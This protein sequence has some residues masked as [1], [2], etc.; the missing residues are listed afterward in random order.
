MTTAQLFD[1]SVMR[2]IRQAS[3][4]LGDNLYLV[5]GAARD[6]LLSGDHPTDWDFATPLSTDEVITLLGGRYPIWEAGR[7]F[8]TIGVYINGSKVDITTFR[9]ET[10]PDDTRFPVINYTDDLRL[11]T[12]RRD[13]T[14][15]SIVLDP[16]GRVLD[17]HGGMDDL[18][19][20][21][22]RAVGVPSERFREDPLRIMRMYRFA[23]KYRFR[24]DERTLSDAAQM[25]IRILNVSRERWAME[26]E[27]ILQLHS[28]VAESYRLMQ[29]FFLESV[30]RYILPE[31]SVLANVPQA[32]RYH[33]GDTALNHTIRAVS[34]MNSNFGRP[35][36][37]SLWAILLHDIGKATTSSVEI[38][39]DGE[40]TSH[41]YGH[42]L[43]GEI[44]AEGVAGRFMLSNEARDGIC[45]LVRN[46]MAPTTLL[47]N[48]YTPRA[49]K[50]LINRTTPWVND[51]MTLAYAD[52]SSHLGVEESVLVR[53]KG[54]WDEIN[55]IP[56]YEDGKTSQTYELPPHL[57]THIMETFGIP[58]GVMVG[59]AIDAVTRAID[60]EVI[61]ST[62]S[63][64]DA[65]A[66]VRGHLGRD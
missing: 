64:E 15:N 52:C 33:C 49:L 66:V 47:Q 63:L 2:E 17:F 5:G 28:G 27:K 51:L 50:R 35:S 32:G 29:H 26:M 43:V 7:E 1:S 14:I 37:I 12:A 58:S 59:N 20:G 60:E 10:Y 65:L 38:L 57:G 22:I 36:V 25:S 42:E 56:L 6:F 13:F 9:T 18:E 61:S 21:V 55:A 54:L 16:N 41:F 31:V 44:Q 19:S 30:G 8:G 3:E 48:G 39:E 45:R 23:L 46:H 40:E 62:P 4:R 34:E 24:V 53:L 11:D